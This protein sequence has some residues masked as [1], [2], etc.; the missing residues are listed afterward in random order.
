MYKTQDTIQYLGEYIVLKQLAHLL[1]SY[2]TILL[3]A[4]FLRALVVR[5]L[6]QAVFLSEA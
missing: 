4:R 5:F 1:Q 3:F 2:A 6:Q